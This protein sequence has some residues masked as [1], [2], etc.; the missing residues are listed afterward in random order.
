M[1]FGFATE[2]GFHRDCAVTGRED[3]VHFGGALNWGFRRRFSRDFE[4]KVGLCPQEDFGGVRGS[5]SA[6]SI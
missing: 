3:A 5:V 6:I 2:L 4:Q 1:L